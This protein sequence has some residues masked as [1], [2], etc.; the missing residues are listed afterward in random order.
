MKKHISF[1]WALLK[2]T[3]KEFSDDGCL[4]LSAALSYYTVFSIAPLLI[5]VIAVASLIWGQE[6]ISGQIYA[7]IHDL[8]G[9][10][11]AKTIQGMIENGYR[12]GRTIL[13][14]LI[15]LA[16]L[17]VGATSVFT[18]LQT[19]L[20]II[21]NVKTKAKS[22]ILKLVRDR[23]LSFG[24]ILAVALLLMVSLVVHAA[25][26]AI[27]SYFSQFFPDVWEIIGRVTEIFF[28]LSIIT[29]LFAMIFKFLPDVKIPWRAVW[30]GSFVTALL[31][32]V[33]KY[34]IGYYLGQSSAFS[35]YGS[36]A[37]LV[38]IILWVNYSSLILFF[39]A[40]FTQVHTLMQ[41]QRVKPVEYATKVKRIEKEVA[42]PKAS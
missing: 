17:L 41:G 4:T 12:P 29:L 10:E 33:G 38:I 5:I 20:N 6:A 31:F 2:K 26:V 16:T 22:G 19:S 27:S 30:L 32:N 25:L 21:W 35:V 13:A 39:G 14:S 1:Y 23:L 24:L 15:G 11:S 8:V 9:A 3:V 42:T 34:L 18:Q 40:E 7:Q 36:A 28:S 37:A